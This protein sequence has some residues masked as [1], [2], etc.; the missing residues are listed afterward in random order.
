LEPEKH[1]E[2]GCPFCGD[3][4]PAENDE[5]GPDFHT[6]PGCDHYVG[7][8]DPD[9]EPGNEEFRQLD[10]GFAFLEDLEFPPYQ[11]EDDPTEQR[12]GAAFGEYVDV[13]A[14]TYA[15]GFHQPGYASDLMF[16]I[17]KRLELVER[18]ITGSMVWSCVEYYSPDAD[19]AIKEI[20]AAATALVAGMASLNREHTGEP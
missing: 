6:L 7:R 13:A 20:S 3:P 4:H 5:E 9:G 10:G 16:A 8:Y 1:F 14:E 15:D 11:G 18:V 2:D 12:L 17:T 19:S